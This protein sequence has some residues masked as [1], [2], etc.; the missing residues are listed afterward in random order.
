VAPIDRRTFLHG[1]GVALGA[2]TLLPLATQPAR[3]EATPDGAPAASTDP[4]ELFRTGHFA[5]ADAGYRRILREDPDS[6]HAL[7]QRGYIALL[8]NRFTVSERFLRRAIELV[9]TD[10]VS[11]YR[12]ADNFVRQD[13]LAA[14]VPLLRETGRVALAD[15]YAG[16][17]GKPYE[18][19]GPRST[20]LPWR[21]LDPLPVVEV[22]VNGNVTPVFLDTGAT[23]V[24]TRAMA[25][26]AGIRALASQQV[27]RGNGQIITIW[28]GVMNELGLGALTLRNVPVTWNEVGMPTVPGA[29][30]QPQGV[31]GTTLFY[32]FLT[33][34]DYADRALVLRR[35][36]PAHQRTVR[37]DARRNGCATTPF[38]L[39]PDHYLYSWGRVNTL[40]PGLVGLDTGGPTLGVVMRD[41]PAALAGVV[42]DYTRPRQF[43]GATVYPCVADEV[44]LGH[45]VRH[46]IPGVVGPV[47]SRSGSLGFT[48]LATITHEFLKP[49][50]LTFDFDDMTLYLTTDQN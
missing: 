47:P 16:V 33:T 15:Q 21:H 30:D 44:A 3:A 18:V 13:N 35:K 25:E 43:F 42:P 8:S 9:P 2:A 17:V 34:M 14:A 24:L 23:L 22:T 20:R 4:D 6:A 45:V 38:W 7:A 36:T 29:D 40:G 1:A 19:H 26:R 49:L 10:N 11:K 50:T 48:S 37:A 31:I 32:H 27:D 39:A 12:L 5:A 41:E 28:F 46:Q